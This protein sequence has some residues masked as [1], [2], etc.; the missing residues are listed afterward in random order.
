LTETLQSG[1][2]RGSLNFLARVTD[3]DVIKAYVAR[4]LGIAV[5]PSIAL[6]SAH[7]VGIATRDVTNLFPESFVG[8]TY[9]KKI[10]LRKFVRAFIRQ[11]VPTF[12]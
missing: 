5:I 8:V 1:S 9:R 2:E 10:Y 4:G 11:V 3:T 6:D 12:R 7:D